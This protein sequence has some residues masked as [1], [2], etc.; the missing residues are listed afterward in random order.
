MNDFINR[1]PFAERL[2]T[3]LSVLTFMALLRKAGHIYL[4]VSVVFLE[5]VFLISTINKYIFQ[6]DLEYRKKWDS[7]VVSLDVVESDEDSGSEVVRWI[8]KFPVS[9]ELSCY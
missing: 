3:I 9:F 5:V 6:L 1:D 2:A 7:M 8:S 4:P